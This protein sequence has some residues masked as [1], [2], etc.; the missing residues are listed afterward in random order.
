MNMQT[1]FSEMNSDGFNDD[2]ER[3]NFRRQRAEVLSSVFLYDEDEEARERVDAD[4]YASVY[5]MPRMRGDESLYV[6]GRD[7]ALTVDTDL[8]D[9][10]MDLA[11]RAIERV[12][13]EGRRNGYRERLQQ[14]E[15]R[16]GDTAQDYYRLYAQVQRD[17]VQIP[18]REHVAK[19]EERKAGL[20]G[21]FGELVAAG[22]FKAP[23]A[24]AKFDSGFDRGVYTADD[25]E[26]IDRAADA[27]GMMRG[28]VK[29]YADAGANVLAQASTG[30]LI[31]ERLRGDELAEALFF[32]QLQTHIQDM[33]TEAEDR[34]FFVRFAEAFEAADKTLMA[35]MLG[36]H[37]KE[38][39]T[40][41]QVDDY[42]TE[43]ARL[44]E[45]T[46]L[47]NPNVELL[48]EGDNWVEKYLSTGN[49]RLG[50]VHAA[51][52]QSGQ[53]NEDGGGA[54]GNAGVE[55]FPRQAL[56]CDTGHV[57]Y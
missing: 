53:L 34:N 45:K 49:A 55:C 8:A 5:G 36:G 32:K 14:L 57:R 28:M 21:L 15:L 40:D 50:A 1:D 30:G 18:Y 33:K 9:M 42:N 47:E 41:E 17:N 27:W 38:F 44:Q 29:E 11:Q 56:Q 54:K 4:D 20:T 13:D 12:E 26:S 7:L 43:R 24:W 52:R 16:G 48:A 10:P 2:F 3:V 23:E 31:M 22:G 19:V 46:G 25:K 39:V 51:A 6:L 35:G 37:F